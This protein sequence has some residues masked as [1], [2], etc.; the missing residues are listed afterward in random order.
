MVR[1]VPRSVI[2][3]SAVLAASLFAAPPA[4]AHPV[5]SDTHLRTV[6]V[7]LRPNELCIRYRLELDQFTTVFKDSKGLIADADVKR[8][9]TPSAFYGEFTRRLGP[10]LADQLDATLDDRP[11]TMRCVEQRFEV[12]DH[13][14]CEFIFQ[15]DWKPASDG[16]HK[17]LFHDRTYESEQGRIRLSLDEDEAIAVR[18]RIL[19]GSLLQAKPPTDLRPGDDER[20]RTAGATFR[21]SASAVAAPE[22]RPDVDRSREGRDHGAAFAKVHAE[23]SLLALLDAPHGFGVLM[24]LAALFGAAHALTPGH[25]KTMVAAYLVGERGTVWHAITL[26]LVTTLTHTGGVLILAGILTWWLPD[27]APGRVEAVLNFVGGLLVAS[28]G[29]WLLL[30]RLAGQADHFHLGADHEHHPD[31]TVTHI[32][33]SGWWRVIQMG[34]GGG[35]VPCWDAVLLLGFAIATQRVALALPLLL[36]FSA[37]LASVLVAI[38]IGVVYAHGL[39]GARWSESRLWRTLPIISATV[40]I[41]L[42]LWLCRDGLN[43]P[44]PG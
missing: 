5:P 6:K 7:C 38:G 41:A 24:I 8:F 40:L 10:I 2:T 34:V 25:G 43:P 33:R 22:I 15:A 23:S 36:A 35:I 28:I 39:G 26:G 16:D 31:G 12:A 30:R 44:S 11:L 20:L 19:P 37:G 29:L 32:D 14:I 42:G 1:F 21:V 4:S 3:A 18:S 17:V 9:S 13:L 27:L